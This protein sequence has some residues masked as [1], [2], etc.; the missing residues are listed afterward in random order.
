MESFVAKR[1]EKRATFEDCWSCRLVNGAL[2]VGVAAYLG[3]SATK[4]KT[5]LNRNMIYAMALGELTTNGLSIENNTVKDNIDVYMLI[6]FIFPI[7]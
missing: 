5:T 6:L 1:H 4:Q 2:I 7:G 3:F